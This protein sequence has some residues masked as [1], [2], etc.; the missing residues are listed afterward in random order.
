MGLFQMDA[1]PIAVTV[2][3][4]VEAVAGDVVVTTAVYGAKAEDMVTVESERDLSDGQSFGTW[5]L[6]GDRRI[7][8]F[9]QTYN[10]DPMI[11][12][13]EWSDAGF[14]SDALLNDPKTFRF[15]MEC[16]E[17]CSVVGFCPKSKA[18]LK[19]KL[20]RLHNY[21]KVLVDAKQGGP[22]S[23]VFIG[24]GSKE[25]TR[26]DGSVLQRPGDRFPR[27]VWSI[28]TPIN[29]PGLAIPF[30]LYAAERIAT[31]VRTL[32]IMDMHEMYPSMR[33][34]R[35]FGYPGAGFAAA[36]RDDAFAVDFAAVGWRGT[37]TAEWLADAPNITNV[38]PT[39]R[40]S[41]RGPVPQNVSGKPTMTFDRLKA[42]AEADELLAAVNDPATYAG[43]MSDWER[44]FVQSIHGQ[45]THRNLTGRQMKV[46]DDIHKRYKARTT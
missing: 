39:G 7:G 40:T 44:N 16:A 17:F 4:G 42:Q 14:A 10:P 32:K 1:I 19:T 45:L 27:E 31:T 12:H 35:H 3:T 36:L 37:I 38:S 21:A 46:L 41:T 43:A 28:D 23:H 22:I 29:S 30:S 8:F 15:L 20:G 9:K 18:E 13:W 25:K 34:S 6:H 11:T 24:F 5:L 2:A 26:P 33:F